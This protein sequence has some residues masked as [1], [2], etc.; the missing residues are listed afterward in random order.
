M[1]MPAQATSR[2]S[3]PPIPESTKLSAEHL[4]HELQPAGAERRAHRDL[5][6]AGSTAAPGSGSPRW[7]RR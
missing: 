4:A 1:R 7:R 3:A 5:A 6:A 2:P